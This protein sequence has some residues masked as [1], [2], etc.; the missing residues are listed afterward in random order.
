MKSKRLFS[1]LLAF[2]MI[3]GTFSLSASADTVQS[4]TVSITAQENS[5]F[6]CAPQH[7]ITVSGDTAE[8]YGFT[9]SVSGGVSAL[10]ALVKLHE[11]KYG[12]DFTKDS[13]AE[14][15]SVSGGFV[16]K[17]FKNETSANGFI[18]NGAYPNDGTA[19]SWGGYNGTTV[20][21][22]KLANNDT[23]EFFIYSDQTNWSDEIA[24]FI[25][26]GNAV[27][28]FTAAP[29]LALKLTLKSLAYMSGYLYINAETIH[30]AG[31]AAGGAQLAYVN[32]STGALT[33]I[34]YAVTDS[35]GEATITA[36]ETEGT[37]YITAYMPDSS[38]GE[39]LIM[40]LAK[41]TVSGEAKPSDACALSSLSVAS[42]DSNPNALTLTPG[43][44]G[45]VTEYSVPAVEFPAM[46]SAV[47]RSVYVKAAAES[48]SAVITAECN[49]VTAALTSGDS[50][51][52]ILNGALEGGKSNKLKITVSDSA[53]E[54]AKT[55]VYTVTVPM[56]QDPSIMSDDDAVKKIY[57]EFSKYGT[58]STALIFPVEYK[59]K[60]YTNIIEYIKAWAKE[61]CGREA[62]VTFEAVPSTSSYT[63]WS[64]G[65]AE[66]RSYTCFDKDGNVTRG[67]FADNSNQT[68]N[69]LKNVSFT[70]GE[71]TSGTIKQI[72]LS[73]PSLQRSEEDIVE[74]AKANLPFARIA[75]GNADAEH[76]LKPVGEMSGTSAV[77]PTTYGLYKTASVKTEWSLKNVI[78]KTDALKLASNKITVTRP[79]VGE[80][81]AVFDLTAAITSKKDSGVSGSITY[82][83]TVPSFDGII[84]PI[85]VTEGAT[86]ALTDTYYGSKF[87]VDDKY[88]KKS[89]SSPEGYDLYNCTLHTSATGTAQKFGYTVSK[90]GYITKRGTITVTGDSYETIVTDLTKSSGNDTMLS[91]L[92]STAPEF[93]FNLEADKTDYSVDVNGVQ[94]ITLAGTPTV[95][96]ATVKITSYYASLKDA[97]NGTIKTSGVNLS[98]SGTKCW[99]PDQAGTYIIKI[100]VTAP[101]G[102]I[103]TEKTCT[104]TITVNK[105]TETGLLTGLTLTASSSGKGTKN[106]IGYGKIPEEETLSPSFV[107][108]G[109]DSPYT[110]TVNYMRD[111]ITVKPTAENC[112]ITVN[113]TAVKSGYPTDK[114]PLETGNNKIKIS[115]G[116]GEKTTDYI[117]NVRRKSELYITGI[118]LEEGRAATLPSKDGSTWTGNCAFNFGADKIHVTYHTNLSDEEEKNVNIDVVLGSNTYHGKAGQPIEIPVG[119]SEKIL[120]STYICHETEDGVT[121]GQKYIISYS[122]KSADSPSSVESYL[123]APGQFVNISSWQDANKT[124][125]GESG[126]TLGSFGGNVVYKYDDPIK[127]DPYNPYGIDFIVFGNCFSNTDGSTSSGAAEAAAVSVSEDGKTWYELAGS[128]YYTSSARK[129]VKITWT[130]GDTTFSAAADT[131]WKTDDGESGTMPKNSYHAQP[132]YPNPSFY[133][134]YQKGI[135]KN[136]SYSEN[137]VSFTGTLIDTGFYPF[138]YADSHAAKNDKI[139]NIAVNPYTGN[140]TYVYNGDGF[141]LDWAVDEEGNPVSLDEISYIKIYNATLSYGMATGEKSAEITQVLRAAS[142]KSVSGKSKGLAALSI[143]GKTIELK[144]GNYSYKFDAE[145]ASA[146]KIKPTAEN[147]NANI[148]VSNQYVKSGNEASVMSTDKVRIIVQ[149]GECEPVIYIIN[150]GNITCSESNADLTSL[151]LTPGD[152]SK[153]P[154]KD[155]KLTFDVS[156]SVSAIRFTPQTANKKA[157]ITLSGGAAEKAVTLTDN[158]LSESVKLNT[159]EN[160]FTL[161]VTSADEKNSNLYTVTVTRDSGN[162]GSGSASSDTI[163]VKFSL[164]GDT[165]HY[166]KDT[167]QYTGSHSNPTWIAQQT[168]T[169]PK[170]STVK[171][172]TELMLNNAGLDYTTD[173]IYISKINGLSDFD[174]GT[175]SGWMYRCNGLIAKDGYADRKLSD[176]DVIKWFYTDDYTKEKGYEGN[177]DKVNSSSGSSG[178]GVYT[179]KFETNGG[180]EIKSQS[181]SNNGTVT[182]P[183]D[184]LREG[185]IFGGWYTDEALTLPYDFLSAVTEGFTLYAK[186]KEDNSAD[187]S[188]NSDYSNK[189]SDIEA[190]AWYRDAVLNAVKNGLFA[191]ISETEFAPKADM[192][193]AMLVTVLY[194]LDKAENGG[195]ATKFT[196]LTEDWYKDAV[197]WAAESGIVS[198]IS[199]THFSPNDKITREQ[200]AAIL[201]RYAN[202][203][204]YDTIQGDMSASEFD[205][206]ESISEYALDAVNWAVN[207]GLIKGMG[208]NTIFPGGNA[209]RAEI[210]AILMRFCEN[211]VK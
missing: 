101:D 111:L 211:I 19:S 162:S 38:D 112:S 69:Y 185:Y 160:V 188:E 58:I 67:Y 172:L 36:P 39:P 184:P 70:V 74:Y 136:E 163:R 191:G 103:Q 152:I 205:D 141:D 143:N 52:K 130:N 178:S 93:T 55:K 195:T 73:V 80:E 29:S 105:K 91:E 68:L 173:E 137:T 14:Y 59:N 44:S 9:D 190:D 135:G 54:N 192:T 132:Y 71:K 149:E 45:D 84:V 196:D 176:G 5:L 117:I 7:E 194:R 138:G 16:T 17:L 153:I 77:L 159:G 124:L 113:G 189:F 128:E 1:L 203:K 102:S 27:S 150:A 155:N 13:A 63:D 23:V 37:Y 104:Y 12:N 28:Q 62:E 134:N 125:T 208:D 158:E 35:K 53:S 109:N 56:K 127:N 182:K 100:T 65:K 180:S 11:I 33:D 167:K 168:V 75:N 142:G 139:T 96:E 31:S 60:E 48:D 164:T 199:E 201:Y 2:I 131:P 41:L 171:Y 187:D 115:V 85:Q 43:F 98:Q 198:G 210:A 25:Y 61:E 144:E 50:N 106:N 129:N 26:K 42:F 79:N 151:T 78:G 34:A 22:Q 89:E 174:N 204:G 118:T 10:D 154:D 207:K 183:S 81:N 209:S 95:P 147:P 57:D 15:L 146:L 32:T 200:T 175:G 197:I 165:L 123:P 51:W 92:K 119:S 186:W 76:I 49:G 46:N 47:F 140:D 179:V 108:G 120:P 24:W 121:E 122:R 30:A 170:N 8:K 114:I 133:S 157:K 110:Y 181:V 116:K 20:A 40:P 87:A 4:V 97:N 18:L 126:I 94:Y 206:F 99:L 6:M 83:L 90:D 82:R 88:I 177:W 145:N 72:R 193:R 161:K 86:L 148:Y 166:D 64:S 202:Y 107:Q 169:L 66:S 156:N 3:F 21:S